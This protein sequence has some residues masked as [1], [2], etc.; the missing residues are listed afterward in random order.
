MKYSFFSSFLEYLLQQRHVVPGTSTVCRK[1]L[2]EHVWVKA[3]PVLVL[4][5]GRRIGSAGLLLSGC[6]EAEAGN[7]APWWRSASGSA[8]GIRTRHSLRMSEAVKIVQGSQRAEQIL[9]LYQQFQK[10]CSYFF[11][12]FLFVFPADNASV[13]T[14]RPG[15]QQRSDFSQPNWYSN[16]V[17][18][19]GMTQ[20]R[21]PFW[22]LSQLSKLSDLFNICQ[23]SAR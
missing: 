21:F 11:L 13:Q 16:S 20:K 17:V 6:R 12:F 4:Q 19:K 9:F 5:P 1:R 23:V 2:D 22:E 18:L 7:L 3:L 14:L 15:K 10:P 8:R